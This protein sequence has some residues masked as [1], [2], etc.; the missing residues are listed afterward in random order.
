MGSLPAASIPSPSPSADVAPSP[1]PSPSPEI[2]PSPSPSPFPEVVLSS[3]PSPFPEV[4]DQNSTTGNS[5]VASMRK[6]GKSVH[7][8]QVK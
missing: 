2:A 5:T 3:Y 7:G 4:A 1:S 6:A 8:L